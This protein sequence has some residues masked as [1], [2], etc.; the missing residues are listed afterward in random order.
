M[1]LLLTSADACRAAGPVSFIETV[2]LLLLELE[3]L[4]LLQHVTMLTGERGR[5]A[6]LEQQAEPHENDLKNDLVFEW[7]CV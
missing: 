1:A 4:L 3:M 2:V 7:R 5:K 6:S